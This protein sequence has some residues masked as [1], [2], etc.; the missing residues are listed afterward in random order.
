[1]TNYHY[2]LKYLETENIII[3]KEEFTFQVETHADYPSLLA[4]ADALT[5][6]NIPNLA[7]KVQKEEIENLPDSFITLLQEEQKESFL[8]FVQKEGTFYKYSNE[9]TVKKIS[10][11]ELQNLWKDVVLL[12]DKPE[13]FTEPKSKNSSLKK[14]LFVGVVLLVLGLVYYFSHSI[15]SFIFAVISM[16]GI[17]LSVEAL[18][19]ELGIESKVSQSFCNAIPNADCGQVINSI[20]N[21]WLQKV[22]ISDLSIWFFTAQI[23]ALLLFS[24]AGFT[25]VFFNYMLAGL[26][27]A[28][29]LTLYSV[30]FQYKIEKKW[31][32]ICLSIIAL[33]YVQLALLIY[34]FT[35]FS[36][37]Q[38]FKHLSLFLFSFS[39]IAISVYLIKPLLINLKNLKEENIKNLRFKRNYSVFKNNLQKEEQ[40]YF[41]HE[42]IILG[43]ANAHLKISIVTSPFCGYCKDA[44]EILHKILLKNKENLCISVRFNF[45]ENTNDKNNQL[46]YRLAE[47]Y[48]EKGDLEFSDALHFWFENKN[49]EQWFLKFG[50]PK[51]DE[52][53]KKNLQKVTQ[54][55]KSK[56]LN[57]TPNI[58]INQYKFPNVYDRKDIEFFVAD[59]VEDEEL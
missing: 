53:I 1:M 51:N 44:H 31:C 24:V 18:K 16:L 46:F 13:N 49:L 3:D 48:K 50:E 4:F 35:A 41:Q 45:D 26:F 37:L 14:L 27:L 55:N 39:L 7:I 58:F 12:V 11:K 23:F 15:I 47:I 21:K 59:L 40:H 5:F 20:K 34:N 6:F 38:N 19:T 42:N 8:S 43:N 17:F 36:S 25:G 52:Q 54:E 56:D 28:V 30:Y 2:L 10:A 9:K 32:P 22:K 29:P 33:V 57:F